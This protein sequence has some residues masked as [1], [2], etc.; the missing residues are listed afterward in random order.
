MNTPDLNEIKD[1]DLAELLENKGASSDVSSTE[2]S[3]G[4]AATANSEKTREILERELQT[5]EE[6]YLRLYA[7]FENL[8]KRGFEE[9]DLA[10]QAAS[11]KI[12]KNI[13]SVV[14][15]FDRAIS[16]TND[17]EKKTTLFV[18]VELIHKKLTTFLESSNVKLMQVSLADRFDPNLHEAITS[19]PTEDASQ[20]G[21]IVEVVE[22][23][24]YLNGNVLR[25][26][27]VIIAG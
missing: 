22:R 3:D 25:F 12:L 18:G 24:Y 15:D 17:S 16:S 19:M 4:N 20:K 1:I 23:G 7:D 9:R 10:A 2:K 5:S 14:D 21:T 8:K 27:K 26:A 11:E 6:Q 13:L